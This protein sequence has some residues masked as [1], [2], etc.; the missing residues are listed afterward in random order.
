[1]LCL[2]DKSSQFCNTRKIYEVTIKCAFGRRL[3]M[4]TKM[5][6]KYVCACNFAQVLGLKVFN[7]FFF[8]KKNAANSV[9][10]CVLRAH[11]SQVK[12]FE[13]IFPPEGITS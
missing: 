7:L 3:R 13:T 4:S 2:F 1:M 10:L 11:F 9:Y 6:G 5:Y 8:F 12:C